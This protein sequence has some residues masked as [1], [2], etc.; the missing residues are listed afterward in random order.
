MRA[1][2]FGC[3]ALLASTSLV[4]AD[5]IMANF[6]GNTVIAKGP[7]SE[8]H[9]HYKADHTFD[10]TGTS[11]MGS[12]ALTGKW[13]IDDKSQLCRNYDTPPPGMTNPVCT[14]WSARDVGDTWTIMDRTVTLVQ[15][16]Q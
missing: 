2:V 16:I 15:G 7:T 3:A 4:C 6:Y 14:P 9:V 1:F 10:G 5:D 12:M 8:V 13:M 11:A